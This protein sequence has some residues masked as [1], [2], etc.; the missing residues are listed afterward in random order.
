MRRLRDRI[1]FWLDVE[2]VA[3]PAQPRTSW[4]VVVALASL[5]ALFVAAAWA[6]EAEPRWANFVGGAIGVVWGWASVR[7][8]LSIG[9]AFAGRHHDAVSERQDLFDRNLAHGGRGGVL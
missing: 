3:D 7:F 1:L 2:D 5:F 9:D 6:F 8:G 4:Q